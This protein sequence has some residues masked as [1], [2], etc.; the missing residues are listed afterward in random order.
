MP[1]NRVALSIILLLSLYETG[2]SQ[3]VVPLRDSVPQYIF[4]FKE[5]EY[6]EDPEG[7]LT[8]GK[9]ASAE[10]NDQFLASP[11]F[12]PENYNRAATYWYRVSVL[13]DRAS[14]NQWQIEFFDQTI[15]GA[16]AS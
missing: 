3:A 6:L 5:I 13:H 16:F 8:I 7:A 2:S 12:S 9:V 14:S 10:Y 11:T 15:D 4:S 1:I